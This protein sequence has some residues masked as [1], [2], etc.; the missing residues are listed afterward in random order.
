MLEF[1]CFE[2]TF[3]DNGNRVLLGSVM[4]NVKELLLAP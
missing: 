3:K 2:L 4:F 1:V